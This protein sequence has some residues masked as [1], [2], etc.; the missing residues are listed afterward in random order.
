VAALEVIVYAGAIM[1]LFIFV[2]ML[3]NLL[4]A[5]VDRLPP[6]PLREAKEDMIEWHS[7]GTWPGWLAGMLFCLGLAAV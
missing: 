5:L 1:V 3:L 4:A 6:G 7:A 2:V